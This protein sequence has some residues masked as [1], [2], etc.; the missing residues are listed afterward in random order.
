MGFLEKLKN[1]GISIP[2]LRE[3][4][5]LNFSFNIDRSV[6]IDVPKAHVTINPKRLPGK[7]R[8]ALERIIRVEGLDSSGAILN[9]R[10]L[11]VVEDVRAELP[12]IESEFQYFL[13]LIPPQDVTMMRA[14]LYLRRRYQRGEQIDD[15]K[16]QIVHSYGLRG[17]NLANLCS[18]GYLETV[19]RPVYEELQKAYIGNPTLAKEKF[20]EF[21]NMVLTEL[22]WTEFVCVYI[23]KTKVTANVISKMQRN[24]QN[25]VRFLNLHGLGES[26]VKKV[27]AVLPEVQE[28][29][30]AISVKLE[31]DRARIFMRLEIPA[32][33]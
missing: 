12:A 31:Q 33:S 9:E 7:Q 26:N 5:I 10:A 6:H 1:I 11:P 16:G 24:L 32:A 14:C 17:R 27:L 3:I 20:L 23:S 8:R 25:G 19:F 4:K 29:T 2:R 22:P 18:A 28:K 21:D 13:S 30:G 15:L